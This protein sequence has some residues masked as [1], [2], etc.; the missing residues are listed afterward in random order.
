MRAEADDNLSSAYFD[1]QPTLYAF[2]KT[3]KIK[4]PYCAKLGSF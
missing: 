3:N 2:R 1:S 4:N